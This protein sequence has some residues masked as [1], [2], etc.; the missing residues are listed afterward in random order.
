MASTGRHG[1]G[2]GR[3]RGGF[4]RGRGWRRGRFFAQPTVVYGGGWPV[5][6]GWNASQ[7]WQA[8]YA[9]QQAALQQLLYAQQYGQHAPNDA[10]DLRDAIERL[11]AEVA[12]LQGRLA[13]QQSPQMVTFVQPQQ[14]Y[15]QQALPGWYPSTGQ[16]TIQP[17]APVE[18][19]FEGELQFVQQNDGAIGRQARPGDRAV[20]V[21]GDPV[22]APQFGLEGLYIR[23]GGQHIGFAYVQ[24]T[25]SRTRGAGYF[26]AMVSIGSPDQPGVASFE[27]AVPF[28]AVTELYRD[29]RRVTAAG[30]QGA[31]EIFAQWQAAKAGGRQSPAIVNALYNRYSR[32]AQAEQRPVALPDYVGPLPEPSGGAS[33]T[34]GW[35]YAVG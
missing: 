34:S 12:E 23:P 5:N 31:A 1:G 10:D 4:R 26:D 33:S 30:I 29:G 22:P 20:V 7:W 32:A 21:L 11:T 17:N 16:E 2:G 13:G 3:G 28:T 25:P 8:Y 18:T 15:M 24:A 35:Y 9:Q 14:P 27:A 19:V 6:Y